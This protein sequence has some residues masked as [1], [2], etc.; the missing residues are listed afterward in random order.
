MKFSWPFV[1]VTVV[2]INFLRGVISSILYITYLLLISYK[3]NKGAF[4]KL[5]T[6]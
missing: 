4:E 1:T 6:L 5:L 3:Y 2:S